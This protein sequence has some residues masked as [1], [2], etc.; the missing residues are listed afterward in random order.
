MAFNLKRNG[1]DSGFRTR[2]DGVRWTWSG[3]SSGVSTLFRQ[4]I[5]AVA[6]APSTPA[7]PDILP[8]G[9]VLKGTYEIVRYLGEGGAGC[10]YLA[11]HMGLGH[12]VAIK[13]LYG[14]F[15]R[16]SGM[17]ERFLEEGIIQANLKHK[18]IV[19]VHD[20]VDEPGFCAFIMEFVG[21]SSLDKHLRD[22]K[23]RIDVADTVRMFCEILEGVAYAHGRS[24]VHRDIKPANILLSIDEG[25]V[26]P[27]LTD[28]GIAKILSGQR[29]TETGTAMGTIYYAPPEQ[30]TDAKS[31]DH[32][33]DIYALG[34]TFFEMLSGRVP[35]NGDSLFNIMKQHIEA[36][37]PDVCALN[38][39]VPPEISVVLR[40]AMAINPTERFQSASEFREAILAVGPVDSARSAGA[41]PVA[42]G[43]HAFSSTRDNRSAA[44]STGALPGAS[45][46]APLRPTLPGDPL[47]SSQ[48]VAGRQYAP[49][50]STATVAGRTQQAT[51]A[52]PGAQTR[53]GRP[54][55]TPAAAPAPN[56][57][58][59]LIV[60]GVIV[61]L[62]L[63]V[64]AGIWVAVTRE[65]KP[66]VEAP[67]SPAPAVVAQTEVPVAPA[68]PPTEASGS[69]ATA[70]APDATGTVSP[71]EIPPRPLLAD[72][73]L[74]TTRY[75]PYMAANGVSLGDAMAELEERAEPCRGAFIAVSDGTLMATTRVD[76]DALRIN[77]SLLELRALAAQQSALSP[78]SH[79]ESATRQTLG[80]LRTLAELA[81]DSS[82]EAHHVSEIQT[83]I[84][85]LQARYTR[86]HA[87]HVTCSIAPLPS[88]LAPPDYVPPV[89]PA[90][91]VEG[92]SAKEGS[93]L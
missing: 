7:S 5:L 11:E 30:L 91:A 13:T 49:S 52:N 83:Y 37:R 78:C 63:A 28:F 55:N 79:A 90:L 39:E 42:S 4:G 41:V 14:R 33:A 57:T 73:R 45:T 25:I 81:V 69:P 92:S 19:Q 74:L 15:V 29:H 62:A 85:D 84:R 12:Q 54:A 93:A 44:G 65:P 21:G 3:R 87:A 20:R 60:N 31:V 9:T 86:M 1:L 72:C 40:K 58:P 75:S 48:P 17:R 53:Q 88:E 6:D 22:R 77:L 51:A 46:A 16:D 68:Q 66:E 80:Q 27:K 38:P 36:P 67:Q 43:A 56:R 26:T 76:V 2:Y 18:N 61:A 89:N 64:L 82:V 59:V 23:S 34:C 24:V 32:R 70:N 35:F 50:Q 8:A 71:N 47:A 10:V